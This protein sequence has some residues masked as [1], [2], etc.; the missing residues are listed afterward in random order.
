MPKNIDELTD[1]S[2]LDTSAAIAEISADLFG[3]GSDNSDAGGKSADAGADGVP[4][5]PSEVEQNPSQQQDK[6]GQEKPSADPDQSQTTPEVQETGAPK[7]WSKEALAEWA[8]LPPRAQQEILKRE[9]DFLRGITQ[10]KERAETGDRFS[11]VVEPYSPILQA[12]NIDPVQMFQSFAANHY[13]LSRGT[14]A[15]KLELAANMIAGYGIDFN[16]L[17]NFIGDRIL[18]PADPRVATLEQEIAALKQGQATITEREKAAQVQQLGSEIETFAADPA[19][20]F[21]AELVDDIAKL[22]ETGQAN[23]LAEAYEKAVYLNPTTRQKEV[24]RL[25]AER[26]ASQTTETVNRQDKIARSTAADLSL[27]PKSRNGTVPI[28]SI[29]DTLAETMARI[30]N[31]A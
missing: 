29:D 15:Q 1:Q 11:K 14:E 12:E 25:T 3:Q 5:G 23:T 2:D 8:T 10:Y 22:F 21:F 19:H 20:P 28:G 26:L 6:T 31:R 24:E 9:E 13:I 4:S 27:T 16:N 18:E 30:A 7:T 17:A